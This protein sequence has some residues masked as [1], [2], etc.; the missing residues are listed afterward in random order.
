[1]CAHIN[2]DNLLP[3]LFATGY[4]DSVNH[5]GCSFQVAT[6]QWIE[7]INVKDNLTIIVLF[8][9]TMRRPIPNCRLPNKNGLVSFSGTIQNMQDLVLTIIID[10]ISFLNQ[11][12]QPWPHLN[13]YV[14]H[15]KFTPIK[16]H[17]QPSVSAQQNVKRWPLDPSLKSLFAKEREF[18]DSN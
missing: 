14:T 1:M 10:S 11:K 4:M 7:G 15:G 3:W 17:W 16:T 8:K 12:A 13:T 2:T 9:P 6:F 18:F 5:Q